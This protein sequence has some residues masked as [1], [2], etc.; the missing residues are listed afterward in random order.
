MYICRTLSSPRPIKPYHF[1]RILISCPSSFKVARGRFTAKGRDADIT[2]LESG[3]SFL[4][5]KGIYDYPGEVVTGMVCYLQK[6]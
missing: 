2:R 4:Q 5:V 1:N 3:M 6:P